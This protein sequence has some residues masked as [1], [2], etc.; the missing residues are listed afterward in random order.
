MLQCCEHLEVIGNLMLFPIVPPFVIIL[1]DLWPFYTG[2]KSKTRKTPLKRKSALFLGLTNNFMGQKLKRMSKRIDLFKAAWTT[3][4]IAQWN[5]STPVVYRAVHYP[6]P[7]RQ[8]AGDFHP[9]KKVIHYSSFQYWMEAGQLINSGCD[10]TA[11]GNKPRGNRP[12]ILEVNP[13]T[14]FIGQGLFNMTSRRPSEGS[15]WN[16][17]YRS[18]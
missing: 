7:E 13:H 16:V 8:C 2:N 6:M 11:P 14:V 1:R 12:Y 5:C 18:N 10:L 9:T 15:L 17:Y 4:S 3:Y